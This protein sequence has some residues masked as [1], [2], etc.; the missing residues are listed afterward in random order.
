MKNFNFIINQFI[1]CVS[2]VNLNLS[3]N[4]AMVIMLLLGV[5][6]AW[7]GGD[8]Y[9]YAKLKINQAG[10]TGAGSV[11]VAKDNSK[12]S[13]NPG[14]AVTSN[15]NTTSG[16]NVTMYYWIDVNAGYTVS[17]TGDITAG[18]ATG[19]TLNG[20]PSLKTA[21]SD[22]EGNANCHCNFRGGNGE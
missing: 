21:T 19:A 12:P 10:A 8:K 15:S 2:G 20:T 9:Y 14:T 17:L 16:G 3:R 7:A 5:G 13:P 4:A 18:P 11:Y 6:N 1:R 22:G